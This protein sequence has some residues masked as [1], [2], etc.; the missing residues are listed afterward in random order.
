MAALEIDPNIIIALK[1]LHSR[2]PGAL[3]E[4]QAMHDEAISKKKSDHS[5]KK[6]YCQT[7]G[8]II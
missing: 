4:L 8:A 2:K 3:E 5:S 7:K 1:L 6:V